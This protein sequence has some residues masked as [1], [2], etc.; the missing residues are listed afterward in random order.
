MTTT[1]SVHRRGAP[2]GLLVALLFIVVA[3]V[4]GMHGLGSHGLSAAHLRV[5]HNSS[6]AVGDHQMVRP[7]VLGVAASAAVQSAGRGI[8]HNGMSLGELCVA[9]LSA[10]GLLLLLISALRPRQDVLPPRSR[11]WRVRRVSGRDRDPPS[12]AQLS[13][14]RR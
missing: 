12:L 6:I 11:P 13:V 10:L 8:D 14:L 3:G 1:C 9:V 4:L 2:G 5:V 7:A